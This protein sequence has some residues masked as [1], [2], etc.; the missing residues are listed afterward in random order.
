MSK[1][2]IMDSVNWDKIPEHEIVSGLY[3]KFVHSETM[4]IA[5]WRFEPGADLPMHNHPHEQ[6]TMVLQGKLELTVG[7]ETM[8]LTQGDT[9]PITSQVMHGGKALEATLALDIFHPVRED[10]R[11]KYG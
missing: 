8:Q 9:L 2:H 10:F 4:T 1:S 3:G 11:E 7:D 6:I 5:Q